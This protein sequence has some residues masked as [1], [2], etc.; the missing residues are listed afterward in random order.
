M[1]NSWI[2]G[3][4]LAFA[5]APAAAQAWD[6]PTFLSPRPGE[7]IGA[8][9]FNPELGGWGY[10]GIWRQEGNL[11]LG[12]RLGVTSNDDIFVGSEFYQP[13]NLMGAGSPLL[14]SWTLGAGATFGDATYLRIPLGASIGAQL[15]TGIVR[16]LPYV[17]PRVALDVLAYDE[18]PAGGSDTET[19]VN[20]VLDVGADVALGSQWTGRVGYTVTEGKS[21]G[22]GIA[23]RF[24][25]RLVVR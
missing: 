11:N 6:T 1:R 13:L 17:H 9:A 23:Y 15:G 5:A 19:E 4:V 12:L 2:A 24:S 20:F 16:V 21:F 10:E 3:V 8:Y 14:M 25:R 22:L 18:A 7:D